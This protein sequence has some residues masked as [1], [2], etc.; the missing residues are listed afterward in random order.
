[1][2]RRG[3]LLLAVALLSGASLARR[4]SARWRPAEQPLACDTPVGILTVDGERLTC[5][6]DPA[7][8]NCPEVV[9]GRRYASCADEGALRG[10]VLRLHGQPIDL[11]LAS[12]ED[13]RSLPGVG[14]GL[15]HRIVEART[16]SALCDAQDLLHVSGI[17]SRRLQSLEGLV[18]SSDVRCRDR[19]DLFR[20]D[21]NVR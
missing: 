12:T 14:P 16:E 9:T 13:L 8:A 18:V 10:A 4:A 19:L 7:L 17:G 21:S 6:N 1:M 11:A 15:A 3:A 20:S 2:S 5:P